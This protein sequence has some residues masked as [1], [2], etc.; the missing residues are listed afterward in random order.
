MRER[1]IDRFT[2]TYVALWVC[3]IL[4]GACHGVTK[5]PE[6]IALETIQTTDRLYL[7]VRQEA[8]VDHAQGLISDATYARVVDVLAKVKVG[9]NAAKAA[10]STYLDITDVQAQPD[11]TKLDA[12][13]HALANLLTQ[14]TNLWKEVKP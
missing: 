6:Q 10:L 3:V 2:Y 9:R 5:P 13:V 12:E 1:T 11:S 14:L 8:G 4:A 7:T